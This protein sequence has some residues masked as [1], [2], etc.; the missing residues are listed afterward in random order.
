MHKRR[1]RR[2]NKGNQPVISGSQDTGLTINGYYFPPV[3]VDI[4]KAEQLKVEQSKVEQ[5]KVEQL[6]VE[7]LKV[8]QSKDS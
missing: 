6:K 2:R 5:S 7:Q 3:S 8:E 1:Y 4:K